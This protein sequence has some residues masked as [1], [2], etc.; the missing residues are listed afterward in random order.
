MAGVDVEPRATAEQLAAG[1]EHVT[2]AP[3]EVGTVELIVARPA[4][5]ER[6]LLQVGELDPVDG[7]V[8]DMWRV[9]G[10]SRTPDGA[11]DP[12]GQVTIMN[13]RVAAL[14]ACTPDRR[15]LAGDQ[16]YVDF[17]LAVANLPAGSRLRIGTAVLE[18]TR[19]VHKGCAKFGE[20][21][22]VDVLRFVNSPT[23]RALRAAA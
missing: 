18:V 12:L 14:V 9:R 6:T 10:S 1:I 4:V 20:R 2:A 15:A 7:L 19:K 3:P 22:G 17:D 23:G 13:A 5:G 16:L 11:A 21:F 8:G